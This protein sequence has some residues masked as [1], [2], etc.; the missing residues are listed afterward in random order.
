MNACGIDTE[1][2][3]LPIPVWPLAAFPEVN[4]TLAHS[5]AAFRSVR[6]R[7]LSG[8]IGLGGGNTA[9]AA[10]GPEIIEVAN[11]IALKQQLRQQ[12]DASGV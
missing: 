12:L 1:E 6:D 2:E 8:E 11:D 9:N 7:F 3:E 5:F 10:D 4:A